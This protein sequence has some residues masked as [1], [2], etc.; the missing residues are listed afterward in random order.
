MAKKLTLPKSVTSQPFWFDEYLDSTQAKKKFFL[1]AADLADVN[2][3][4]GT[5]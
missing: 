1:T 4:A 5:L 2:Y 3:Y